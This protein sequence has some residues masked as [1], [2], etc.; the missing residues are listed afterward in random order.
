MLQKKTDPGN[1]QINPVFKVFNASPPQFFHVV[2]DAIAYISWKFHENLFMYMYSVLTNVGFVLSN[3]GS[4]KQ[5]YKEATE[6]YIRHL[7]M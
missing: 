6:A 5:E 1:R 3:M 4:D 2:P 7:Q